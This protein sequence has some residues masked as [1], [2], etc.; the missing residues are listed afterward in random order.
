MKSASASI[1]LSVYAAGLFCPGVREFRR[2]HG[3]VE[4]GEGDFSDFLAIFERGRSFGG[5]L[6][7][8]T[9]RAFSRAIKKIDRG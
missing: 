7:P 9:G 6:M 4:A 8:L 2:S 5:G 1:D 3:E